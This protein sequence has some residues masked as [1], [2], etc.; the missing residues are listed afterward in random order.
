PTPIA[1]VTTPEILVLLHDP[2]VLTSGIRVVAALYVLLAALILMPVI[3][4]AMRLST[5]FDACADAL[6]LCGGRI[7][8]HFVELARTLSPFSGRAGRQSDP[9]SMIPPK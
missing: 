8:A 2:I 7:D 4:R 6:T 3:R 1:E 9:A 5:H